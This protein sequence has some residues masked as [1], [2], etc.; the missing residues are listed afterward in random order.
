LKIVS[1]E[2]EKIII[3]SLESDKSGTYRSIPGT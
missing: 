3:R 1:L 2:S